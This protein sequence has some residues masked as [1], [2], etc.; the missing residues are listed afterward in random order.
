[1]TISGSLPQSVASKSLANQCFHMSS[2]KEKARPPTVSVLLPQLVAGVAGSSNK[3]RQI[4][5][6]TSILPQSCPYTTQHHGLSSGR[7]A[8]SRRQGGFSQ[9][10]RFD[11]RKAATR[12]G[13]CKDSQA[14]GLIDRLWSAGSLTVERNNRIFRGSQSSIS[15]SP[16]P[17]PLLV[18]LDAKQTPR[19]VF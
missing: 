16:S 15:P 17:S 9:Q 10:N 18:W 13:K 6:S 11:A 5:C 19:L 4:K 7:P 3:L 8:N 2:K 12:Q 14:Q 1:M